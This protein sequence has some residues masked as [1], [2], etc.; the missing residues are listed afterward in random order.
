MKIIHFG[1][2]EQLKQNCPSDYAIHLVRQNI[3]KTIF[4]EGKWP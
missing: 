1:A 4:Q 3:Q 2:P